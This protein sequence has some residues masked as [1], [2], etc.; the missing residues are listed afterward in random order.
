[1]FD[2]KLLRP[3]AKLRPVP[4][5]SW[6]GWGHMVCFSEGNF[7]PSLLH[8]PSHGA[9]WGGRRM[10]DPRTPYWLGRCRMPLLVRCPCFSRALVY[11]MSPLF[12][13]VRSLYRTDSPNF[14]TGLPILPS[15]GSP[16]PFR[17]SNT[18]PASCCYSLGNT[19][20]P[21]ILP[22][23]WLIPFSSYTFSCCLDWGVGRKT[24]KLWILI[25]WWLSENLREMVGLK[26]RNLYEFIEWRGYRLF[27][28]LTVRSI[29][30]LNRHK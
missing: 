20:N 28:P 4:L 14:F 19:F 15:W 3:P 17:E 29:K 7:P 21:W 16:W 27:R 2:S 1:M 22:K 12:T 24:L 11:G 10:T 18:E 25:T 13:L 26:P 6:S 5:E 30:T 23:R 9:G 8:M